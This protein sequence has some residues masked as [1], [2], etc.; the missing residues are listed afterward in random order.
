M[1]RL[2]VPVRVLSTAFTTLQL[3][4]LTD[5]TLN[6]LKAARVSR[7]RGSAIF[8]TSLA[9]T[10]DVTQVEVLLRSLGVVGVGGAGRRD[11]CDSAVGLGVV[12]CNTRTVG[13]TTWG[14]GTRGEVLAARL[15]QSFARM[16]T[17]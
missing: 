9:G 7:M 12:V 16:A 4:V 8:E 5:C 3:T 6:T 2:L 10:G 13:M 17:C 14:T 11:G 1:A 15:A